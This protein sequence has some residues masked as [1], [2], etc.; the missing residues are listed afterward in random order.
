MRDSSGGNEN[1][2][3]KIDLAEKPPADAALLVTVRT[4]KSVVSIP[5]AFKE[6]ALP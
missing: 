4:A 6:V 5:M 1:K 3:I 2:L